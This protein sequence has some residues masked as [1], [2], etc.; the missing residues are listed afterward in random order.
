MLVKRILPRSTG[1][2]SHL[3][4]GFEMKLIIKWNMEYGIW[5][6]GIEKEINKDRLR[7]PS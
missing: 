2:F 6:M 7:N 3:S 1:E 5:N 4:N